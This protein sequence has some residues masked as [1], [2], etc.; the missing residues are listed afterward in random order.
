MKFLTQY[1]S[2]ALLA[3]CVTMN[4]CTSKKETTEQKP[5]I[6]KAAYGQLPDGQTADL[7]TLHNES[8]MTVSITNYGGI[9]VSLTTPD[10]NGK[11]E[12][13]TLG[14]DSRLLLGRFFF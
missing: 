13:V 3:G 12:D 2:L 9:I 10:R 14:M 8:G 1:L 11:F 4:A 5:G 6:D 7:Y